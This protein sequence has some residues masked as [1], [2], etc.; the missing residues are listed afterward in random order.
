MNSPRIAD[1]FGSHVL[2]EVNR[3]CILLLLSRFVYEFSAILHELDYIAGVS[4]CLNNT[5]SDSRIGLSMD[6]DKMYI[7]FEV[8]RDKR[9]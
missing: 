1:F 8:A 3:L 4:L 5:N 2:P 6:V 7:I 9:Q